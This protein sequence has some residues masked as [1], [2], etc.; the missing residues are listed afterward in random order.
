MHRGYVKLWRKTTDNPLMWKPKV[1]FLWVYLLM[2]ANYKE[3]E[4]MLG[5]KRITCE[6][7]QFTTGR[8]QICEDTGLN[9]SFV[10]RALKL[11]ASEHQIEQQT[12]NTNRLITILNW[13]EYQSNEQQMS[14]KRATNEQQVSTPKALK[15]LT[16]KEESNSIVALPPVSEKKKQKQAC[17]EKVVLCWNVK[18]EGTSIPLCKKLSDDRKSKL[19]K[20]LDDSEFIDGYEDAIVKITKSDFCCGYGK[21]EW[22]ASFDWFIANDNNYLKA[23]EGKYDN[24]TKVSDLSFLDN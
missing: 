11:F 17:M 7:G 13:K 15:H 9:R 6:A 3:R 10:E 21:S 22:K 24:A 23:L 5:G 12:T 4:E 14:N 1:M 16:I 18:C 2:N 8:K 19:R 20:R